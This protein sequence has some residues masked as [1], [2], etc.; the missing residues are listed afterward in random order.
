MLLPEL[1]TSL[2]DTFAKRKREADYF[3]HAKSSKLAKTEPH[4]LSF[5]SKMQCVQ[6]EGISVDCPAPDTHI[7]PLPLLCYMAG[8]AISMT[9]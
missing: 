9:S 8:L 5:P 3:E 6:D 7:P 1:L 2:I 4:E